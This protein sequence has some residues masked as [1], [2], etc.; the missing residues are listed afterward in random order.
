MFSTGTGKST[1]VTLVTRIYE[2]TNTVIL[3]ND[4]Q[5]TFGLMSLTNNTYIWAAPEV[6]TNFGLD[7]VRQS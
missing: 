5:G 1:L 3:G 6:K 2:M 7:Q 4:V